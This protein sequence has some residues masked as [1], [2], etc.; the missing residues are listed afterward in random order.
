[1]KRMPRNRQ[2]ERGVRRPVKVQDNQRWRLARNNQPQN[3]G[4]DL[5]LLRVSTAAHHDEK[6]INKPKEKHLLLNLLQRRP[7]QR[8]VD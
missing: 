6:K 5:L 7:N 4:N 3:N 1:M 8:G 2:H